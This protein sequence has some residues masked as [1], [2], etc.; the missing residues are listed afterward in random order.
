ML[1]CPQC[2]FENPE[3]H[4]YCQ[5]CGISLTDKI[6]CQCRENIPIEAKICSFCNAV[7]HTI[8]WAVIAQKIVIEESEDR[9]KNQITNDIVPEEKKIEID[10]LS[11]FFTKNPDRAIPGLKIQANSETISSRYEAED[12]PSPIPYLQTTADSL[13]KTILQGKVIDKYPLQKSHLATLQKQ[14][15]DLFAELSQDLSNSYLSVTQYWNLVGV[16]THA[17]P[18]LILE[19]YTPTIPKIYD[20]WQQRDRGVVL[21]PDRSQWKLMTELWSQQKLPLLQI[22][23]FLDEMAKLWE[24]LHQISCAQSLLVNDNLRIDEDQSFC[25][26]QL[27]MDSIDNPPNLKDLVTAWQL[28][29]AESNLDCIDNLNQLLDRVISGEIIEVEQLRLELHNLGLGEDEIESFDIHSNY[30]S[31]NIPQPESNNIEPHNDLENTKEQSF[32]DEADNDMIYS[33]EFE[34]QATAMIPMELRCINNASC[35]DIGSQRDHNE[36]FFG[37]RT[38]IEETENNTDSSLNVNGLYL[39]CDGMGG[40]AAGEVASAMA[41]ESLQKYFKTQWQGDLPDR[42]TIEQGILL[43]NETLYQTNIDNSRSGSGRMGTTLVMA[44][45]HNTRMAIA[46]VGDSRIYR[47]TRKQGLEQLTLDHEVGQREINRGVE[48]DI[49]YGRPDAYQLTQALGPRENNYVRP[50]IQ[51]M[52]ITEDCLLLLCSDGLCDNYLLEENWQQYLKPL[53]SSD[54]N[55]QEGLFDLVNFANEYNGHDNITAILVRVKL[56]PDF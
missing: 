55:L 12:E 16:P 34:E 39:V 50:D 49:A 14:Q 21:L 17:L 47:I 19:K 9:E 20:A 44:L 48:P 37:M 28:C 46:H 2:E 40:H 18:Y 15:M 33:S 26:Q 31:V 56:K 51:F 53:I 41:V 11:D 7:N 29:F 42:E 25:F 52:E 8:L 35:T 43:T 23:W 54:T 1:I 24:P 13:N 4:K 36:D 45:L 27:Y 10:N 22:I 38:V 5:S 3:D 32:F 6:C 30:H